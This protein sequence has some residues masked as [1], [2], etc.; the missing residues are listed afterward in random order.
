MPY[1]AKYIVKAGFE[2]G[3]SYV[4]LA[5]CRPGFI[6]NAWLVLKTMQSFK[7]H[8]QIC[9][10]KKVDNLEPREYFGNLRKRDFFF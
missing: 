10:P 2:M 7:L 6:Y 4:L 1:V 8:F 5:S 9:A 3:F